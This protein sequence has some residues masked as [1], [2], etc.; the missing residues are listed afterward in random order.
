MFRYFLALI[1][2]CV[3]PIAAQAINQ[4][5]ITVPDSWTQAK[6]NPNY[7]FRIDSYKLGKEQHQSLS[8]MDLQAYETGDYDKAVVE[9]VDSAVVKEINPIFDVSPDGSSVVFQVVARAGGGLLDSVIF[10][11]IPD[12]KDIQDMVLNN[13]FS[14]GVS[15]KEQDLYKITD[16]DFEAK[17]NSNIATLSY[18]N[19]DKE[20]QVA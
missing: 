19:Q 17:K 9:L 16:I 4:G 18:K 5:P 10:M 8:L 14:D 12:A 1:L 13:I 3:A 15:K 7:A 11:T 20:L 2:C 6:S